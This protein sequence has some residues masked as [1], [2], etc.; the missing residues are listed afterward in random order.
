MALI[1]DHCA[2][3]D[4][5]VATSAYYADFMG[6]YLGIPRTIASTS[7]L[8]RSESARGHGGTAAAPTAGRS[9]IGVFRSDMSRRRGCTSWPKHFGIS[10]SSWDAARAS[11]RLR[12]AGREQPRLL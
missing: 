4:G 6:S 10:V 11:P 7:A 9:V 2:E 1:R 5:F 3:M 12:L 8:P